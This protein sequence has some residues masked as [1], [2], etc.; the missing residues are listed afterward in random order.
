MKVTRSLKTAQLCFSSPDKLRKA[1]TEFYTREWGVAVG[2]IGRVVGREESAPEKFVMKNSRNNQY[3]PTNCPNCT[4]VPTFLVQ[5][6]FH[7]ETQHQSEIFQLPGTLHL[8]WHNLADLFLYA[9]L[10][11]V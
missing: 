8:S 4:L 10:S 3:F 2:V 7:Q 11:Y 6:Q 1:E 9:T 5:Q